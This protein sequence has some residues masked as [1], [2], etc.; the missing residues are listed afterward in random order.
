MILNVRLFNIMHTRHV[1]DQL[2]SITYWTTQYSNL[3]VYYQYQH[4]FEYTR[5]ID[6]FRA[7]TSISI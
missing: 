2:I 5:S 3:N 1:N 4:D 6:Y 7:K